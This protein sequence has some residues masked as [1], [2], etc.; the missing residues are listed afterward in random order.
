M[1]AQLSALNRPVWDEIHDQLVRLKG[2]P[3]LERFRG[4]LE[5]AA[6]AAAE[7]REATG[8]DRPQPMIKRLQS[9]IDQ[10]L[11]EAVSSDQAYQER[12]KAAIDEIRVIVLFLPAEPPLVTGEQGNSQGTSQFVGPQGERI[13]YAES[14]ASGAIN[15]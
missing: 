14:P 2:K 4:H 15:A 5:R 8:A 10:V 3:G 7:I 1:D 13:R 9:A 12:S 6:D 11:T